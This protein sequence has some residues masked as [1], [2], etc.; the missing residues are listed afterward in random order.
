MLSCLAL[1]RKRPAEDPCHGHVSRKSRMKWD[2][3][4]NLSNHIYNEM[5]VEPLSSA[6][7]SLDS[8]PPVTEKTPALNLIAEPKQTVPQVSTR[9]CDLGPPVSGNFPSAGNCLSQRFLRWPQQ[10]LTKLKLK[11]SKIWYYV[12]WSKQ[13]K[14]F[15]ENT[16]QHSMCNSLLFALHHSHQLQVLYRY[17]E[18]WRGQW[19]H[20]GEEARSVVRKIKSLAHL[21]SFLIR[22][23]TV[24]NCILL[25][26]AQHH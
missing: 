2:V 5:G 3:D 10:F 21:Q 4:P 15:C 16:P 9:S 1:F 7:N 26:H 12:A 25:T 18:Q 19:D 11:A 22:N 6:E 13:L 20:D 23:Y 8:M 24:Q 17:L 14:K